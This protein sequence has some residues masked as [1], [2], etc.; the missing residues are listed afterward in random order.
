MCPH[1]TA[2]PVSYHALSAAL[3]A[4]T[5]HIGAVPSEVRQASR[6]A[7]DYS[8]AMDDAAVR[9]SSSPPLRVGTCGRPLASPMHMLALL[10]W[11][12]GLVQR[13]LAKGGGCSN[14]SARGARPPYPHRQAARA[15]TL[16][17]WR[18]QTARAG[19][20]MVVVASYRGVAA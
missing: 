4:L 14:S 20:A 3:H 12:I 17:P 2:S 11:P 18:A 16:L 9:D 1:P 7:S 13:R 6:H 15:A 8:L 19:R 5:V 10:R